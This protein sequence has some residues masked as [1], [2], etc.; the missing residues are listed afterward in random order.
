MS[1]LNSPEQG[2]F[3][4]KCNIV[5]IVMLLVPILFLLLSLELL[6]MVN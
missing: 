4:F 3:K 2:F 1:L 6:T 5:N